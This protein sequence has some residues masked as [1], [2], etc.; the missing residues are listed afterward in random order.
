MV[1]AH[2]VRPED[3]YTGRGSLAPDLL[4]EL[5]CPLV[6]RFAEP[7]GEQV[8]EANVASGALRNQV[9]DSV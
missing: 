2:A 3:P 7:P 5:C 6:S 4:F 1:K 8:E 9:Q